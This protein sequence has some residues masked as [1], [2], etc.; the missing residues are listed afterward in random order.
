[1]KWRCLFGHKYE[2]DR[3]ALIGATL[4]WGMKAVHCFTRVEICSRCQKVR[5]KG[6]FYFPEDVTKMRG[7]RWDEA[8]WPVDDNGDRLKIV[9]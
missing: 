1:M 2:F 6:Q 3:L 8:G 7:D 5:T 9:E 4:S